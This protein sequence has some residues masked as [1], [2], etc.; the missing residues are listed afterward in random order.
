MKY[1]IKVI[2]DHEMQK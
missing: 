2:A 1:I